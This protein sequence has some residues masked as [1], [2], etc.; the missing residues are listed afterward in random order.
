M[1]TEIGK[2]IVLVLTVY[3]WCALADNHGHQGRAV[4]RGWGAGILPLGGRGLF[5]QCHGRIVV[6]LVVAVHLASHHDHFIMPD[7]G[8]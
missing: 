1:S 4:D 3:D 2:R 6:D 5:E 8:N 7:F